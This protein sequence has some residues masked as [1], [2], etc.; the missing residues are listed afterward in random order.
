LQLLS[1]S[2][3]AIAVSL[4]LIGLPAASRSAHQ[5]GPSPSWTR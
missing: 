5:I 1:S 2:R 4:I 3:A